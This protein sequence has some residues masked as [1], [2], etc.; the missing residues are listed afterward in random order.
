VPVAAEAAAATAAAAAPTF[1]PPAA[2]ATVAT[3][4][5][6][7]TAAAAAARITT[8]GLK[9]IFL[10]SQIPH[11]NQTTTQENTGRISGVGICMYVF[12]RCLPVGDETYY[13]R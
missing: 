2:F 10:A 11:L 9:L 6:A 12:V 7:A 4:A 5:I 8:V 3:F 13:E 1:K